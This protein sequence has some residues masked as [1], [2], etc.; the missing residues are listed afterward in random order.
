VV[1][2]IGRFKT[3]GGVLIMA[4]A[5]YLFTLILTA[6]PTAVD[7]ARTVSIPAEEYAYNQFHSRVIDSQKDLDLF[8]EQ[9][10]RALRPDVFP[11]PPPAWN[12]WEGFAK[13][14]SDSKVDFSRE[15]FVLI[16]H[17]E[18]SGSIRVRIKLANEPDGTLSAR[19]FREIPMTLTGDMKYYCFA[20]VVN[21]AKVK[22]VSVWKQGET[23][24][25]ER[26]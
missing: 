8:V 20:F 1:Y 25:I 16:Q 12:N 21:K 2:T 6:E 26:K 18:V 19:I 7:G 3:D 9:A 13:G 24:M 22:Q 15:A 14:I 10:R 23:L 5:I 11:N 17:T 4:A